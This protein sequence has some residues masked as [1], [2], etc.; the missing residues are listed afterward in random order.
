MDF[1]LKSHWH[2]QL[3]ALHNAN[4]Q[5]RNALEEKYG[6]WTYCT[7][8]PVAWSRA[9][10]VKEKLCFPQPRLGNRKEEQRPQPFAFGPVSRRMG[11]WPRPDDPHVFLSP[12]ACL[13]ASL[14]PA[15]GFS[16]PRVSGQHTQPLKRSGRERVP[17]LL[18]SCRR[19]AS[20]PSPSLVQL[21]RQEVRISRSSVQIRAAETCSSAPL[22]MC[23][24]A[25]Q[26]RV[27]GGFRCSN[28]E[29]NACFFSHGSG[30]NEV[31][32]LLL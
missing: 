26:V 12:V 1:C 15:W 10:S 19:W 8:V 13:G 11:R 31:T 4:R 32:A 27:P 24:N 9:Y 6:R 30:V 14:F 16:V 3:G 23:E 21:L 17:E 29:F 18:L 20:Q 5:G 22:E 25:N 7:E 2:R 28:K